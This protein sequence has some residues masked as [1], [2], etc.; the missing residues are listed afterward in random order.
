VNLLQS[1]TL[2]VAMLAHKHRIVLC[3]VLSIVLMTFHVHAAQVSSPWTA[4]T[5]NQ[6]GTSLNDLGVSAYNT[7]G[8]QST[9]SAEVAYFI[10]LTD[11]DDDDLRH[12]EKL[13][14]YGTD[15]TRADADG[16]GF[17]TLL[18]ADSDN[19]GFPDGLERSQGTNPA[20]PHAVPGVGRHGDSEGCR[21]RQSSRAVAP[22]PDVGSGSPG[23]RR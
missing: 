23:Q 7:S 10:P 19:D 21:P 22:F 8:N 20:D 4:P 12:E 18:D 3:A 6:D 14:V 9:F 2:R 13:T 17:I 1:P 11:T 5:T 15:P 16:G